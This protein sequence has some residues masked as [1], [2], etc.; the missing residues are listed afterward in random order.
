[1]GQL[2]LAAGN[3]EQARQVYERSRAAAAKVG[4]SDVVEQLDQ[5]LKATEDGNEES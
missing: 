5:L 3:R 2:L 4:L 1:L